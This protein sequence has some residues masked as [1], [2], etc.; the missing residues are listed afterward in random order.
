MRLRAK[1]NRDIIG[2]V[3]SPVDLHV[4]KYGQFSKAP[5]KYSVEFGLDAPAWTPRA[6]IL[7]TIVFNGVHS[8]TVD[9]NITVD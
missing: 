6:P 9:C 1:C 3:A 7:V 4:V 8:S 2:A 5:D